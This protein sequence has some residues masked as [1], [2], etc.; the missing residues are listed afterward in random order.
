MI[1]LL[2]LRFLQVNDF[3][4]SGSSSSSVSHGCVRNYSP[5]GAPHSG[6][7][8]RYSFSENYQRQHSSQVLQHTSSDQWI[9][10]R[11]RCLSISGS[12]SSTRRCI[13]PASVTFSSRWFKNTVIFSVLVTFST[14]R[15]P[16]TVISLILVHLFTKV[17]SKDLAF[18]RSLLAPLF[19]LP[20]CL[21]HR[22]GPGKAL[23]IIYNNKDY[24]RS[25]QCHPAKFNYAVLLISH[26]TFLHTCFSSN[27]WSKPMHVWLVPIYYKRD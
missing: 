7:L 24:S 4:I 26:H 22:W 6:S 11:H 9:W 16:N 19:L 20:L 13:C 12:P 17:V 27:V 23:F 8:Q 3:W 25:L 5:A 14:R 2:S 10:T 15:S 18:K 1:S 21:P